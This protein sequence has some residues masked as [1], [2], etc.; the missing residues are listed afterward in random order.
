MGPPPGE[1]QK[2]QSGSSGSP[3]DQAADAAL[4]DE[5]P[6]STSVEPEPKSLEATPDD[7]PAAPGET[8]EDPE[9]R[10]AGTTGEKPTSAAS[11][12]VIV[13]ETTAQI[14]ELPKRV[15]EKDFLPQLV[16][17][18]V[19][20]AAVAL[21][22]ILLLAGILVGAFVKAKSWDDTKQLLD[23]AFP[24][25]TGLLGSALGFYFGKKGD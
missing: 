5:R 9:A 19:V 24:A 7:Q 16:K 13:S 20:R 14:S 10:A 18:E 15:K 1:P 11:K 8:N 21:I 4:G 23:V 25:V 2:P 6:D 22:L 12:D 3:G 17:E